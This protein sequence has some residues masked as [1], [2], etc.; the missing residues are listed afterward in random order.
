MCSLHTDCLDA[1]LENS[2]LG[3]GSL[4]CTCFHVFPCTEFDSSCGFI[5]IL[6]ASE[7]KEEVCHTFSRFLEIKHVGLGV[8]TAGSSPV[9]FSRI[10]FDMVFALSIERKKLR[11]N[12]EQF[13]M[14]NKRKRL[15]H[16]SRVKLFLVSKSASCFLSMH[17]CDLDLWVQVDS[18][19]QPIW[20]DSVDSGY[21][22]HHR[23]SSFDDRLD[24]CLVIFKNVQLCFTLRRTCVCGYVI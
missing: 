10:L 5:G 20:R 6:E 2:L 22:S 9:F 17:I 8:A 23:T 24:H 15:P 13:M 16:S 3:F 14:L 12:I 21:V 4:P 18:V 1:T 7:S 19:K 11:E